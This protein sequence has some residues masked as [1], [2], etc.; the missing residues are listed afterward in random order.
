MSDLDN[1]DEILANFKPLPIFLDWLTHSSTNKDQ[2]EY[3]DRLM[4]EAMWSY[5]RLLEFCG[6]VTGRKIRGVGS[7]SRMEANQVVRRRVEIKI[8]NRRKNG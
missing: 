7:L 1:W 5:K 2:R 4:R 3:L 6:E 8:E